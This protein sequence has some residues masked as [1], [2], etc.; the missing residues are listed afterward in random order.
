MTVAVRLNL[1][2]SGLEANYMTGDLKDIGSRIAKLEAVIASQDS[3]IRVLEAF[4]H[5]PEI[6]LFTIN[7]S[8]SFSEC[9][10]RSM[11]MGLSSHSEKN[12][13]DGEVYIRSAVNVRESSV[14]IIASIYGDNHES[15]N[16]KL[17]KVEYMIGAMKDAGAIR[18][19][20]IAPYLPYARSDRKVKSREAVITKYIAHKFEAL[21]LDRLITMDVHSLQAYQNAYSNCRTDN[22][23]CKIEF[24]NYFSEVFRRTPPHEISI[25]APDSGGFARC[26]AFRKVLVTRLGEGIGLAWFDKSHDEHNSEIKRGSNIIGD[27]REN[28]ICLDDMIASGGTISLASSAAIKAGAKKVWVAATHGLFVGDANDKL[29]SSDIHQIVISDTIEPFR[30]LPSVLQK[31]VVVSTADLFAEA[32]RRTFTG[33]SLSSMFS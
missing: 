26:D 13:L 9:V 16:D 1:K 23:E 6:K 28:M 19:T 29:M 5:Q 10:A 20:L 24:A 12:H 15:V 8:K 31:V 18:V 7:G 4:P 21:G 2:T 14:F 25:L 22:L 33:D 32:I 27:I 3:K 11:K 30:L 17:A